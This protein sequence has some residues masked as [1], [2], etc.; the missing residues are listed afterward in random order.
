M[1]DKERIKE[2][3]GK[4]LKHSMDT[5]L[6][7]D[8]D[9]YMFDDV[10]I[11]E[12]V[13]NNDPLH[14]GRCKIVVF[15]VFNKN[16]SPDLL[17]WVTPEIGFLGSKKG[18]LIVPPV[19]AYVNVRF[20]K[21]NINLPVYT[22]RVVNMSNQ[23]TNKDKNYPYNLIFFETDNGDKSEIDLVERSAFFEHSS[24]SKILFDDGKILIEQ[25]NTKNSIS[26]DQEKIVINHGSGNT[27]TLDNTGITIDAKV[28]NITT[29]HN[30]GFLEDNGSFVI[31]TNPIVGGPYQAAPGGVC[32]ITGMVIAGQKCSPPTIPTP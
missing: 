15:G 5:F 11:G 10:Y 26:M 31:P 7:V 18:S 32:P 9:P 21:D 27:I 22:S 12:V 17:P 14:L 4:E 20:E 29:K 13:D 24:G 19:G 8:N 2:D 3:I 30:N 28:G 1:R 25:K 6:D 23:P 16:V